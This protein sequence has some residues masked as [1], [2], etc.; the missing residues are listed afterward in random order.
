MKAIF[1]PEF[2]QRRV[3]KIL[4]IFGRDWFAGR[5]IL[6]LGAAHGDIGSQLVDLGGTVT[7][8]D[9]RDEHLQSIRE[10][11]A[12]LNHSVTTQVVDQNFDYNL[13]QQYDLVLHLGTL[14]HVENWQN[15]LR[16]A[17]EHSNTMI[18]ESRVAPD[19][20]AVT[21]ARGAVENAE[22]GLFNCRRPVFTQEQVEQELTQLGC[23]FLRLDTADLNTDWSWDL[24]PGV[25]TRHVY[26]WTYKTANLYAMIEHANQVH[27]RRMWLVN[28]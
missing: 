5:S 14:Y 2:C 6:E 1:F 12:G 20:N 17:L 23:K 21:G 27:Y 15:D 28:K 10:R 8:C 3:D 26:D 18:L 4:N 9:A 16:C 19:C 13:G 24:A 11:Y 25:L 22:Y 7:F